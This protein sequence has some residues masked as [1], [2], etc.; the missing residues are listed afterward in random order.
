MKFLGVL[1]QDGYFEG[2]LILFLLRVISISFPLTMS[3]LNQTTRSQTEEA[4][5][6]KT[7]SPCKCV[8]KCIEISV[9]NL[10]TDVGM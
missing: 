6:C 5:D 1:F 10:H 8:R 9:E 3:P 4:I 2:F 7:N